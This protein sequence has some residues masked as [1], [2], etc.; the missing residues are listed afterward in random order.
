[1]VSGPLGFTAIEVSDPA[2]RSTASFQHARAQTTSPHS[3]L[4]FCQNHRATLRS[5]RRLH[6]SQHIDARSLPR[7]FINDCDTEYFRALVRRRPDLA[8][9]SRSL[10]N[11]DRDRRGIFRSSIRLEAAQAVV[12]PGLPFEGILYRCVAIDLSEALICRD[13]VKT[14]S[15]AEATQ[16]SLPK[17]GNEGWRV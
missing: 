7:T 2:R 3:Y 14:K 13:S 8:R 12:A 6:C 11:D 16:R 5:S 10:A 1:M 9:M 4:C 15:P 17:T